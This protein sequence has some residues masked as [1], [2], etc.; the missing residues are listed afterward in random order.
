MKITP[1]SLALLSGLL[2]CAPAPIYRSG[3]AGTSPVRETAAEQKVQPPAKTEPWPLAVQQ[4]LASYYGREFHGRKTANGETF[5]MEAM[6]AAHRT[7]PF[8]TMVRVTNIKTGQRVM[9]KINDRGPFVDGRI[10]DLSQG[11]ARKIG[12]EGVEPVRLEIIQQ[13][14]K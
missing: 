8:G 5:D 7:L 1:W 11:A 12:I 13:T 4:G 9:V 14:D 6:T 10:I 3:T 2:G